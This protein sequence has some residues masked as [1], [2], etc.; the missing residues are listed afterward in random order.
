MHEL[1]CE[2]T[3]SNISHWRGINYFHKRFVTS[4]TKAFFSTLDLPH[5]VSN[6]SYDRVEL[7]AGYTISFI[8]GVRQLE[9]SR[10]LRTDKV[11]ENLWL[12]ERNSK[13]K[14]V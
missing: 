4:E 11:I 14:H 6:R 13:C 10:M 2:F 1:A 7:K 12:E 9:H 5:Q 3:D 8:L